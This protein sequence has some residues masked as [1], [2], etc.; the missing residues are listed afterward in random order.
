MAIV[1]MIMAEGAARL[2]DFDSG[3]GPWPPRNNLQGSPDV[4]INGKPAHRQGDQWAIHCAPKLGCH[5]S[6]LAMGSPSVFTNGKGQG[7]R[8]DLVACGSRIMTSSSDV[9]V[10]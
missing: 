7:R 3:H 5:P 2:G 8:N 6:T 1:G 9:F 4:F 10:G